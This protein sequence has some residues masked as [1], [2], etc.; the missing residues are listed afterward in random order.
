M[1]KLENQL[2]SDFR[3]KLKKTKNVNFMCV[4]IAT[5]FNYR[6]GKTDLIGNTKDGIIIAIEAKLTKWKEAL[7]QAYKNTIYAHMS[8]VLLPYEIAEN[9]SKYQ[10]EF[11]RRGIGLCTI[12]GSKIVV[13]IPAIEN[14]PL[15]SWLTDIALNYLKN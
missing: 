4:N 9:A 13:I 11:E 5:E 12:K 3:S 10:H 7:H 15:F 1:Y 2:V 14:K 8:Y 6:N